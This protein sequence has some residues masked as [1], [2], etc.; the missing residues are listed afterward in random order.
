M[1][2]WIHACVACGCARTQIMTVVEADTQCQFPLPDNT[3]V[4]SH[5]TLDDELE[6]HVLDQSSD[7]TSSLL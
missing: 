5:A 1:R 7:Q 2:S 3:T 6:L 4:C